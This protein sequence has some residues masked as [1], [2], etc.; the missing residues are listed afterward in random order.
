MTCKAFR[1]LD[2]TGG[3][4]LVAWPGEAE[5]QGAMA[6]FLAEV[7]A[8]LKPPR[9]SAPHAGAADRGRHLPDRRTGPADSAGGGA[10]SGCVALVGAAAAPLREA[11]LPGAPA[12]TGAA[13]GSPLAG[14][15]QRARPGRVYG[16]EGTAIWII[17]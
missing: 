11:P 13:R 4:D 17:N 5:V 15:L 6:A 3:G 1:K 10:Q 8:A 12:E 14:G 9:R 16:V 2:A 7:F